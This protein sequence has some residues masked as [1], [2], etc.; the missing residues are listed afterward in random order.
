MARRLLA[1]H[2]ERRDDGHLPLLWDDDHR[3]VDE[4]KGGGGL[5]RPREHRVEVDGRPD[6]R[7][8]ARAASL[9]LRALELAPEIPQHLLEA[10][11]RGVEHA[12]EL[13]R[14][15]AAAARDEDDDDDREHAGGS[16]GTETGDG[17]DP[18]CVVEE[19]GHRRR[20]YGA[21]AERCS[22]ATANRHP[23]VSV[24]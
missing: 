6:R 20:R 16:R 12:R 14:G 19:Q 23:P 15:P 7:E 18:G 17:G 11:V 13:G 4:R 9:R 1:R 22:C 5:E 24:P 8:L 10:G 21:P 2:A 3:G